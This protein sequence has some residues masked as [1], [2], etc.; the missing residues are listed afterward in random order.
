MEIIKAKILLENLLDRVEVQ[1]D[2]RYVL[3]GKLTRDELDAIKFALSVMDGSGSPPPDEPVLAAG[4]ETV[5]S[6]PH[7]ATPPLP[8]FLPDVPEESEVPQEK[9]SETD[10]EA[11]SFE[12]DTSVLTLED[13]PENIRLCLDFGTAMSKATLVI[14]G[15]DDLGGEMI[16]VLHLGDYGDGIEDYKLTSA[17]YID[18]EGKL[19]FGKMAEEYAER[20][21]QD[22]SPRQVMDNIK[23]WLSLGQVDSEVSD[24]FNP[25]GIK[26][27][28]ADVILAYLT[29]LT[30]SVD[31]ALEHMELPPDGSGYPRNL[32]RRFAMPCLAEAE[33]REVHYR[34]R[35]YLGEA[36]IL[37]D[38]FFLD[39]RDGL[40][41]K[42]FVD[43]VSELRSEGI[44]NYKFIREGIT[45][46]LGV[47]GTLLNY[48]IE[49]PHHAVVM[50]IDIGAGTSDFSMYRMHIDPDRELSV[51]V[52]SEQSIGCITEAGNHLDLALMGMII[53]SFGIGEEHE[54]WDR[55]RWYLLRNIREFKEEIFENGK[56]NVSLPSGD[57][58]EFTLDQFEATPGVKRFQIALDDKMQEVL[59]N[60]SKDWIDLI[61]TPKIPY[62][63]VALT[64]GGASL[65]MARSLVKR[66]MD[67]QGKTIRVVPARDFPTWL[68]DD[69]D[70][71]RQDYPRIAVS[72]G[73]ARKKLIQKS[74]ISTVSAGVSELDGTR[75]YDDPKYRW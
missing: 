2:G 33:L 26:L 9:P 32:N 69:H 5:S 39:I 15:E 67:V 18:A 42:R 28:Y 37:A 13:A 48:H 4:Q 24:Q 73:G 40:D 11:V 54:M 41:L 45:E 72:L 23:H 36:Q 70:E 22:G 8:K 3:Q 14:D 53:S 65:P 21:S 55:I 35:K 51:A 56:L 52:E 31:Q 66:N 17:V 20:D 60:I 64:G 62:L 25:S 74:N 16:S 30:W 57:E 50:V 19:W 44:G 61:G 27:T 47:A 12:I 1:E 43:A 58:I 7:P 46:P 71:L 59:D 49:T 29:F 63:M 34:L 38:T 68:E 75:I 10:P 6:P